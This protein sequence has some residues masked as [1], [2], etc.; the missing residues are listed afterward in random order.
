[1]IRRFIFSAVAVVGVST[2]VSAES[3]PAEG[4]NSYEVLHGENASKVYSNKAYVGMGYSYVRF[5]DELRYLSQKDDIDF[6]G[7]AI[8]LLAGYDF[9]QYI[10]LEGRYSRTVGDVSISD[11]SVGYSLNG[12]DVPVPGA[13]FDGYMQNAAIYV[14]PMYA[15]PKVSIYGLLGYGQ[16]KMDANNESS[17]FSEN[18]LQWGFGASFSSG[19]H[20][21]IFVDYIRLYG[22]KEH[23]FGHDFGASIQV[24]SFNAGVAYKF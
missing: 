23:L 4:Y 1:M 6:T 5:Q 17:G 11:I 3:Y 2:F 16:V 12:M 22:E 19:E 8:T 13:D 20:L 15:T 9:N 18:D 10:G 24:D 7:N 21:N 14:K